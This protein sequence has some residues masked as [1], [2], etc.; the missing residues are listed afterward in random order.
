VLN[1]FVLDAKG[2][3]DAPP[4]RED[5]RGFTCWRWT[6]AGL[7]YLLVGDVSEPEMG[8]L[9]RAAAEQRP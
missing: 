5:L 6:S 3:R 2:A 9:A 8:A 1:L 4:R 7:R